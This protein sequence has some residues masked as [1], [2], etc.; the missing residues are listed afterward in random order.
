M[1]SKLDLRKGYYQVPVRAEDIPKTAVITPF[2][3]WEFLR[4]PFGLKNAGQSF[5][6]L[7][8]QLMAGLDF[9]FVYLDDILIASPDQQ[10]HLH[11]LRL[12]LERVREGGLLLNMDKCQFGAASLDFLGH[13]VSAGGLQPLSSHVQAIMEVPRPLDTTQLQRFLSMTNFYRRFIPGTARILLPLTVALTGGHKKQLTWGPQEDA[14]FQ[15]AKQVLCSAASLVHPD[16]Q[17]AISLAV[18]ASDKHV[19]AVL[20]QWQGRAWA[21]LAF[22]SKKLEAAQQKYSAFDR[23][24]LAAYLAVRHFHSMLHGREF[25]ILSDHKP[26]SFA[27]D[28]VSEPWSASQQRQLAF[29]SEFTGDIQYLPGKEN[30]VADA[31]S[32]PP[33]VDG[34][35]AALPSPSAS[36]VDF[37]EAAAQQSCAD[38]Q[39]ALSSTVLQFSKVQVRDRSLW[40]D[41]ST[42]VLRPLVP[43]SFRDRI[44]HGL[45]GIDHPGIRASRRLLASRYMWTGIAKDAA[46]W[47]RD[48]QGCAAGKVVGHTK[49]PLQPIAVPG[50]RFADVHV[51]LVGPFPP[52]RDG[53]TH[54]L[55]IVDRTTRWPEA[56]P[57]RGTTALEC[58]DT[59]FAGWLSRFGVPA[60]LTSDRGVQFT[61]TVWQG[62]CQSFGMAH[63]QTSAYHPQ[64]NGLVERFHRQLMDALRARLCGLDWAEHLPWVLLGLRAA[65]KEDSAVSS[66]ELVLGSQLVLPGQFLDMRDWPLQDLGRVRQQLP[67]TSSGLPTRPLR[68]EQLGS[69]C[70]SQL[71]KA[72]LVY[73]R[74]GASKPPLQ[75]LYEGPCRVIRAGQKVFVVDIGGRPQSVTMDRLKPHLGAAP[76]VPAAPPRRGRPPAS[77]TSP[78]QSSLHPA[79]G[80]AG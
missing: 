65:P 30:V 4:M 69:Y 80:E 40:C 58:T 17:A 49:A 26:L 10:T 3:L 41:T 42:G 38:T 51:D 20:Q 25:S 24:L 1:F 28:R 66:A 71:F 21:P 5:Q 11:H 79:R 45:H 13:M 44:F 15:A 68:G 55:T 8:D 70:P 48:C 74:V 46:A 35:V 47:C 63:H 12:V 57:L 77:R 6:R 31:L 73:I 59:F 18:D 27:I 37:W 7:M 56:V 2:G 72:E 78:Q 29:I 64:A 22:F 53:F 52:S 34:L 19:G 61:S 9:V 23:E 62:L 67:A 43:A 14:A 76:A 36:S 32:R 50:R 39:A 75:P 33:M 16:P 60:H 54:V